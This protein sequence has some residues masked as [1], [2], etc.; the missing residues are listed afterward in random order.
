MSPS[1]S[2]IKQLM[3]NLPGLQKQKRNWCL[4]V[5]LDLSETRPQLSYKFKR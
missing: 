1:F 5:I 2:L 3:L 4:W